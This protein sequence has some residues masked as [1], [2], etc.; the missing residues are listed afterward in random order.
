MCPCLPLSLSP[1]LPSSSCSAPARVP[2]PRDVC[3][4]AGPAASPAVPGAQQGAL[5]QPTRLGPGLPPPH[6]AHAPWILIQVSSPF[7]DT[8]ELLNKTV[9]GSS[10][11]PLCSSW[12]NAPCC[13]VCLL[14]RSL[15]LGLIALSADALP[16][17]FLG[18]SHALLPDDRRSAGQPWD[19]PPPGP[20]PLGHRVRRRPTHYSQLPR[21]RPRTLPL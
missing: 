3:V 5:R 18:P 2:C 16:E 17:L 19:S 15:Q 10:L 8:Q 4:P 13:V 12:T 14:P 7:L 9:Q 11:R 1:L 6:Q 20:T 21:A